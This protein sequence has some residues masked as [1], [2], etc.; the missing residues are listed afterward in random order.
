MLGLGELLWDVFPDGRQLGGAPGNF[1]Y[2]VHAHGL[3][4]APVSAV[5]RDEPGEAMLAELQERGVNTQLIARVEKPTG[6]VE[7]E[8]DEKGKPEYDIRRDVAWDHIPVTEELLH[9]ARSAR[10]ICFGSLAQRMQP[11]RHAVRTV[12]DAAPRDCLE[13]FDVNLRAPFYSEEV[14][15]TGLIASDVF[16]L[17]DDEVKVVARLVGLPEDE[18]RFADALIDRFGLQMLVITRGAEGSIL[19][20][21]QQRHEHPGVKADVKST[22]GAGD[23]FTATLV[24][25]ILNGL[26]LDELHDRAA[27]VAAFVC[28]Q[29]GAMPEL[30]QALRIGAGPT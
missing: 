3:A 5:G 28:E 25:G 16:K 9:V 22:V 26:S 27:R 29:P 1:A 8:L 6:T 15:R 2:H 18:A 30:P 20:T 21:P 4:G 7:V 19:Q 17:S 24:A 11:S 14:I 23:S 12:L 13:V 10:A